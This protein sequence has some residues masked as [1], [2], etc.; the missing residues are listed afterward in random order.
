[1]LKRF[2]PPFK[3]QFNGG[4]WQGAWVGMCFV[5]D[6]EGWLGGVWTDRINLIHARTL[7]TRTCHNQSLS[8]LGEP[9]LLKTFS[10]LVS[11]LWHRTCLQA[12]PPLM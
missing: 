10:C 11:P 3:E 6:V 9:I 4:R 8:F 2:R 5:F 12:P 7:H 1:M